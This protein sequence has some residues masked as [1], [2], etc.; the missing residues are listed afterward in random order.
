M[1]KHSKVENADVYSIIRRAT[2]NTQNQ[3]HL[4]SQNGEK[5]AVDENVLE[6]SIFFKD[7]LEKSMR[8]TGM[9][10]FFGDKKHQNPF[11]F[12]FIQD[13]MHLFPSNKVKICTLQS[14]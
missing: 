3:V 9:S 12:T 4:I 8:K 11:L 14:S 5:V 13:L 2:A 1:S 7:A 10:F 6:Q